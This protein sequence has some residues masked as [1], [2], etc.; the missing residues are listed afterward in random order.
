MYCMMV[1]NVQNKRSHSHEF[2]DLLALLPSIWIKKHFNLF[3]Y[4]LHIATKIKSCF[5]K[6]LNYTEQC[7]L[8]LYGEMILQEICGVSCS[9]GKLNKLIIC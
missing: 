6:N 1:H 9:D 8:I 3:S 2:T 4:S 7:S 5:Y